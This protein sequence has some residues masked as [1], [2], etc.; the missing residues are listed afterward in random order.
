MRDDTVTAMFILIIVFVLASVYAVNNEESAIM[1]H[2]KK[3]LR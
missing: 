3:D 2:Q 1:A